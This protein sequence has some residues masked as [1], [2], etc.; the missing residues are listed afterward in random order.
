MRRSTAKERALP[1]RFLRI[2]NRNKP[3]KEMHMTQAEKP[4][5]RPEHAKQVCNVC[6]KPSA[7]TICDT[8]AN[9]VRG[10]AL[11]RKKHEEKLN[12]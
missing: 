4:T 1:L 11:E 6:G 2:L 9:R 3:C 7:S 5:Q 12:S 8:C 10:E